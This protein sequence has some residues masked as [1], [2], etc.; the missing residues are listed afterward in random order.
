MAE[1]TIHFACSVVL[2]RLL[3]LQIST[4]PDDGSLGKAETLFSLKIK[5]VQKT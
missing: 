1:I 3:L 2:K 5:R 4:K